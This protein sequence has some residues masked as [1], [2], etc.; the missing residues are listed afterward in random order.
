MS[1]Y[2]VLQR[3]VTYKLL[4]GLAG[5][6]LASSRRAT[7]QGMGGGGG[8]VVVGGLDTSGVVVSEDVCGS[9]NCD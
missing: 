9:M 7:D 8:A 1:D 5:S 2:G 6:S 4:M 3:T